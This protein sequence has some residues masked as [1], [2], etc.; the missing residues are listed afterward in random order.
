MFY[1]HFKPNIF[2]IL[3][4]HIITNINITALFKLLSKNQ[5]T[6][7]IRKLEQQRRR[8]QLRQTKTWL[9]NKHLGNDGDYS[10]IATSSS[11]PLL[12]TEHAANGLV[13]APVK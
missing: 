11:H 10:V 9:E 7:I 3:P 13:E 6:V 5:H 1:P 4:Y 12:L 8:Q 2:D